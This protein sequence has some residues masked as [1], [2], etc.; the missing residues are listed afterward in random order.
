MLFTYN[1]LKKYLKTN[2]TPDEI[3]HALTMLGLEIEDMKDMKAPLADFIVGEI[4]DFVTH[5][6]SDNLHLLKV[7]IFLQ[8]Q[9]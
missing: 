5:P 2:L 8:T 7:N 3:G 1:Q 9:D 4:V 6:D